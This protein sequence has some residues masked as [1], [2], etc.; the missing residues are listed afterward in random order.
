MNNTIIS[1]LAC[2]TK[3]RI[4]ADKQHLKPNCGNCKATIDLTNQGVP[5][6]LSDHDFHGFVKNA[7]LPVLVLVRLCC[8][9]L[10]IWQV[11][12]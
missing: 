8:Q 5:V 11:N 9:L 6:E 4:P 3:N 1:C 2:G 7:S 10:M 12:L